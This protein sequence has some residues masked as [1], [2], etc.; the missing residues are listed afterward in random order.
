MRVSYAWRAPQCDL[1]DPGRGDP[2]FRRCWNVF[3]WTPLQ[4][5]A[6]WYDV[7]LSFISKIIQFTGTIAAVVTW[8]SLA[9]SL[10]LVLLVLFCWVVFVALVACFWFVFCLCVFGCF[11]LF[12][13][14]ILARLRSYLILAPLSN[15]QRGIQCMN[16]RNSFNQHNNVRRPGESHRGA[17][18]KKKMGPQNVRK[19]RRAKM[20]LP[21]MYLIY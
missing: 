17:G 9:S 6:L 16:M 10:L 8:S 21:R 20:D 19:S 7:L 4:D 3:C 2:G 11:V 12:L 14:F 13:C 5:L 1:R 18:R 15:P